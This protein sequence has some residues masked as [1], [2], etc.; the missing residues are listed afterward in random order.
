MI[1]LF[2]MSVDDRAGSKWAL[3]TMQELSFLCYKY[4]ISNNSEAIEQ[5]D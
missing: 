2:A 3:D 5:T 1:K 4:H